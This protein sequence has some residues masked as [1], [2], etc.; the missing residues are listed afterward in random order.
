MVGTVLPLQG[1]SL[2]P[3]WETKILQA[4]QYGILA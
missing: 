3:G 1:M 2:I 4:L